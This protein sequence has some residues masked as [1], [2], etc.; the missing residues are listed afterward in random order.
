M[1]RNVGLINEKINFP[2]QQNTSCKKGIIGS[3]SRDDKYWKNGENVE[4]N[5][6]QEINSQ[7]YRGI[8]EKSNFLDNIESRTYVISV[9]STFPIFRL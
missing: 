2:Y 4:I 5:F 8:Y 9:I 6:N 7:F 1:A 3:Y